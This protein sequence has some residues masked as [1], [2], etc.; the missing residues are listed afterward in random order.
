MA[1]YDHE[2]QR[3]KVI[4]LLRDHASCYQAGMQDPYVDAA[5]EHRGHG[6]HWNLTA[7]QIKRY[8]GDTQEAESHVQLEKTLRRI[9]SV[10]GEFAGALDDVFFRAGAGSRDLEWLLSLA[11][12]GNPEAARKFDRVRF[13]I[14]LLTCLL[15]EVDLR[16]TFALRRT[17]M[18][19]EEF[20]R[21]NENIYREL[22]A[23]RED[24][25]NVRER[26]HIKDLADRYNVSED[27]IER[28]R[29]AREGPRRKSPRQS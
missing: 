1:K 10:A 29:T 3:R 11:K 8:F 6:E 26:E 28:I 27:T 24:Y 4:Q 16:A 23:L 7:A 17:R 15:R 2:E 20:A 25:P 9:R 13:G 18:E 19:E 22:V 5:Q 12:K 21:R 14:D